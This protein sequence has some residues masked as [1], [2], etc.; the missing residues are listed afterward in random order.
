MG[1]LLKLKTNLKSLKFGGDQA[2]GGSSS[3]PYIT[4]KIPEGDN[5]NLNSPDFLL[6]GGSLA[7][8]NSVLDT[9]R[10]GKYFTDL[11]SPSGMLFIAKQNVLSRVA[12]RTETSGFLNE[13]I[14]TPLSTLAQAG[15]N[16]FGFH[17]NK[18]GLNPFPGSP[19]S[20]RTYED[21]MHYRGFMESINFLNLN[22]LVS[23]Y[24]VKIKGTRESY[25]S[26]GITSLKQDKVNLLQYPGGPGSVLGVGKTTYKLSTTVPL[27]NNQGKNLTGLNQLEQTDRDDIKLSIKKPLGV[28]DIYSKYYTP[29]S[30]FGNE[31]SNNITLTSAQSSLFSK[32]SN[33][34]Y[35]FNTKKTIYDYSS[36]SMDSSQPPKEITNSL[37]YTYKELLDGKNYSNTGTGLKDFRQKLRERLNASDSPDPLPESPDYSTK[38]IENRVNLG[39]PGTKYNQSTQNLKSYSKGYDGSGAAGVNSY[40]K[41]T[42]LPL[43]QSGRVNPD[44]NKPVNDLVK[45]RIAAIDNNDPSEKVFIHFRAFLNSIN[46]SYNAD[47]DSTSYVGRGE[48]FYNYSGFDRKISLSFTVAAQSKIELIPMY[49][50]LNYLAS[51]LAPDYSNFGYMRGPLVQLTIGGYLYEQP[52]YITSLTYDISEDTTWEI[53]IDEKGEFDGT[54]KELPHIIRVSNFSFTPIHEFVPSKQKNIFDD[55]GNIQS[56]GN[57]HF[58]AL[59][60]GTSE[61]SN[62]NHFNTGKN[63]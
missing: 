6:R 60:T 41:I 22:R 32:S 4:T 15:V 62:Y 16:A 34:Y 43:Y 37:V 30:G 49:K 36:G 17:L 48:K 57:E 53:G 21:V 8:A 29:T 20:I 59:T 11:K 14:Y 51:Q 55:K 13:N 31:F 1:S 46:D 44:G 56:F 52:G 47:W 26:N 38:N 19:G 5:P 39:D 50:K 28:S 3:Q 25:I 45:F 27:I 10:L 35:S 12:S 61:N 2:G 9:I 23:L 42:A 63:K 7:T 40:D 54:V 18:Q 33:W 58:I 24:D